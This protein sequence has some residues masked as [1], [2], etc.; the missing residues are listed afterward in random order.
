MIGLDCNRIKIII[1]I[2]FSGL[3]IVEVK[4]SMFINQL[5]KM[6]RGTKHL[7]LNFQFLWL[8]FIFKFSGFC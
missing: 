6:L 5:Q 2:Y 7:S 1:I 3:K 8:F 4:I